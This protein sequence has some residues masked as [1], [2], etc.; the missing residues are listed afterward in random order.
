[1]KLTPSWLMALFHRY[2]W[3]RAGRKRLERGGAAVAPMLTSLAAGRLNNK[4]TIQIKQRGGKISSKNE[5][6]LYIYI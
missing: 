1:M 4:F 6:P 2:I 3:K 5:K